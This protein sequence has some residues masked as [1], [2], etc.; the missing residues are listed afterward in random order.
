MTDQRFDVL[1]A[2]EASMATLPP[3]FYA[4]CLCRTRDRR[5]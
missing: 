4:A 3:L 1:I 2:E 5:R